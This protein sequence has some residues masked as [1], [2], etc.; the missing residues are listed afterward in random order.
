[1]SGNHHLYVPGASPLHRLAPQCKLAATVLFV[2]A[3]VATPREAFGAFVAYAVILIGLTFVG[4]IPLTFVLRRLVIEIPF[5]A[6]ALLLPVVGQ[7]ERV[8]VLGMS[9][10]V[11]GL[12]AM[13]NI[14]VKAT[15]GVAATVI[16]AATTP[17]PA[18]LHGLEHLRLPKVFVG[19]CAFMIRYADVVTGEMHRMRVAR[20]SRGSDPRWL[21]QA[22]ATAASAGTS[23][24]PLVRA[25]RARVPRHD[26]TR[27]RRFDA[28][29]RRS[30][31]PSRG[32]GWWRCASPLW[33]SLIAALA[34]VLT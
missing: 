29:A 24:H 1:M 8:E 11:A 33:A 34:W 19:I 22:R 31:G 5:L 21:W 9:L 2:L 27:L 12:W 14:L 17:V 26:L 25:R 18:L 15:L 10:S 28:A 32:S 7:G 6:F 3:I 30:F 23:V 20:A 4:Q 16:M 13:W